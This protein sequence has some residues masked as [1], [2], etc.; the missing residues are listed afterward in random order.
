MKVQVF[1]LAFFAVAGFSSCGESHAPSAGHDH[2]PGGQPYAGFEK[3]EIKA[4]SPEEL[5]NLRAGNGMGYAL[6]AE[7]NGFPGPKHILEH[8]AAINLTGEQ[9]KAV[10]RSFDKMKK[11]AVRLGQQIIAEER[12]LDRLFAGGQIDGRQLR[13]K[14]RQIADLESQLRATHLAAHLEMKELLSEQQ[15]E[16]Y[17]KMRGYKN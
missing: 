14:T 6:A 10:R 11:E 8:E 13:A 3:R 16:I 15:I 2:T 12:K 4:F 17:K 5:K 7:L 1:L 9:K